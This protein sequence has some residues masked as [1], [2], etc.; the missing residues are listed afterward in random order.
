MEVMLAKPYANQPIAGWLIS[1]KLDGVRA[2][3][4]GNQLLTRNGNAISAPQ[5]FIDA[6]PND[7]TLDGELFIGRGEFQRTVG[8]VRKKVP[9]DAEWFDIR[10][11]VFDAPLTTGGFEVRLQAARDALAGRPFSRVVEHVVCTGKA[12]LDAVF[13]ALVEQGAEGVMLRRP[14]STYQQKRSG[15]LLKYKPFETDEAQVI[16]HESGNGRLEGLVGALICQWKG[17][18]FQV[19]AG[20]SD[21]I[22]EIPPAVGAMVTFG[23]CGLTD[24][25][26]PR[27]PT[28]VAVRDYE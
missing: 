22:R 9:V 4:N 28:F 3:W 2:Y 25:G 13:A 17:K 24:G 8:A 14:G 26:I 20:M 16:G 21:A 6:L 12:H 19:G 27:F 15:D 10:Y 18:V 7:I 1:E 11:M 5:W 23:F